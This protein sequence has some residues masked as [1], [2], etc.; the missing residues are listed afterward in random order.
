V[1]YYQRLPFIGKAIS[2]RDRGSDGM[3]TAQET[4]GELVLSF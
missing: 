1:I 3:T 2:Q 4:Q